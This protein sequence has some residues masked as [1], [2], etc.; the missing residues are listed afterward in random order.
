MFNRLVLAGTESFI[1]YNVLAPEDL[2]SLLRDVGV[3]EYKCLDLLDSD[4][5]RLGLTKVF[6]DA[7]Q[8]KRL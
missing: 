2:S 3:T 4:A 5:D 7:R 1:Y 6:F 8:A